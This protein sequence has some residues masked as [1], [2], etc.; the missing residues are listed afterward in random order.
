MI[1]FYLRVHLINIPYTLFESVQ[2]FVKLVFFAIIALFPVI[3]PIGASFILSPYFSG[4]SRQDRYAAVKRVSFYILIICTVTLILGHWI[5]QL[6]GITVPIV[7]LAGGIMICKFGWQMLGS[8]PTEE[9]APRTEETD[10]LTKM[11]HLRNLLFYPI[12]FPMTAGAGTL[13]VI[14]TLSAHSESV[15][16]KEHLVNMFAIFIAIVVMSFLVFVFFVNAS[17]VVKFMGTRNEQIVNRLMAFLIFCVGLQI[18]FG[19]LSTLV[20]GIHLVTP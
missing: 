18:A 1:N 20:K 12:T 4:L 7:Q 10:A 8:T 5:L 15:K 14:F 13:S 11:S 17:R 6:F 3:N 19:G 2:P 9:S 16:F